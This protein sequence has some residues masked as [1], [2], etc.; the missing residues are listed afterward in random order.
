MRWREAMRPVGMQR[1]ALLAPRD[2]L[3]DLLVNVADEG[4][5]ELETVAQEA[6]L[7]SRR[8]PLCGCTGWARTPPPPRSLL[9]RRTST[10]ANG[11][12]EST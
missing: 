7:E 5:V 6:S 12:A 10:A 1:V 9:R 3:R 11:T 2:T 8:P 4:T